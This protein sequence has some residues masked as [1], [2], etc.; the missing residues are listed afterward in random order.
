M[1]TEIWKPLESRPH[2]F[3]DLKKKIKE[4]KKEGNVLFNDAL[5]AFYLQLYKYSVGPFR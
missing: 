2:L 1:K 4:R 3:T 5:N